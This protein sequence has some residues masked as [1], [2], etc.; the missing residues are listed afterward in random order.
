LQLGQLQITDPNLVIAGPGGSTIAV[1]GGNHSRVF[2]IVAA[3]TVT[4]SGLTIEQGVTT[5]DGSN[6]GSYEGG[7]I[8]NQG[9]LTLQNETISRNRTL[10]Q[11]GSNG[12]ATSPNGGDGGDAQGGALFVNQH[13]DT[14]N[15]L[16]ITGNTAVG[17]AGRTGGVGGRGGQSSGRSDRHFTNRGDPPVHHGAARGCQEAHMAACPFFRSVMSCSFLLFSRIT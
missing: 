8:F 6:D 2:S 11:A 7:D 17:S 9:I 5:G 14:L 16:Q 15:H 10:G 3:A 13:Q 4:I 1:S 12:S